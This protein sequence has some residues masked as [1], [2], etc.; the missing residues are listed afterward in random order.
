MTEADFPLLGRLFNMIADLQGYKHHTGT[1]LHYL[2]LLAMNSVR[3][4][5][6]RS[7]VCSSLSLMTR[8]ICLLVTERAD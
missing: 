7:A 1:Q 3:G 8:Q 5:L 4:I 2:E 6:E